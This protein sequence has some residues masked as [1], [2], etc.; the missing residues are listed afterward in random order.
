[1]CMGYSIHSLSSDSYIG[2]DAPIDDDIL[3]TY[4]PYQYAQYSEGY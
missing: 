2:M 1:M 4:V 3:G